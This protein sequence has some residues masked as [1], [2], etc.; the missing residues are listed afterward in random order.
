MSARAAVFGLLSAEFGADKVWPAHSIDTVPRTGSFLI[1][2]WEEQSVTFN[3]FGQSEVLTVWAH[4]P[5]ESSKDFAPL[6]AILNRTT[7]IL[8]SALHVEGEDGTLTQVDYNGMSP[9]L[10][11]EG[12]KTI[13]KNAAYKVL[14]R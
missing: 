6:V 7:E 13:T 3:Q 5:R 14:S 10:N 8:T 1:L 4:H 12:Y 2:R 9:D 11:D